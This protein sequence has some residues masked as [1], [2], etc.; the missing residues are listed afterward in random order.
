M[1]DIKKFI[2]ALEDWFL[3]DDIITDTIPTTDEI[4]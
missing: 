3:S 2:E 1:S 4:K